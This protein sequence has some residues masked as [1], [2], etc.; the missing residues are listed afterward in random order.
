MLVQPLRI[1]D[2]SEALILLILM[3]IVASAT[4]RTLSIAPY[5]SMLALIWCLLTLG[6]YRSSSVPYIECLLSSRSSLILD[7]LRFASFIIAYNHSNLRVL[8]WLKI[9]LFL[10]LCSA[11]RLKTLLKIRWLLTAIRSAS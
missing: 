9:G 10:Q 7:P 1:F 11:S 6:G 2:T 4:L 5:S 8:N 3:S